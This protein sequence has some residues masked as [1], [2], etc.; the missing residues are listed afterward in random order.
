MPAP[1]AGGKLTL[2][3]SEM[4]NLQ[5]TGEGAGL[6]AKAVERL[7]KKRDFY[8]HL[9]SYVLINT[10]VVV[11]WVMTGSGF[12]WP[13]FPI[14]G[15]GIGLVFHAWD[16]WQPPISEERIDRELRAMR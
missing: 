5:D 16:V 15:W 6:R 12:F 10:T 8:A 2:E 7:K 4:T 13:A 14:L 9:L 3:V 11:I 1:A